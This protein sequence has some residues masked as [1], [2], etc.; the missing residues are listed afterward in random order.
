MD[1]PILCTLNDRELQQRRHE[2]LDRVQAA[3]IRKTEL[4]NGYLY[5]FRP[6]PE[7]VATLKR[8]VA[9]EQECCRFLC[10]RISLKDGRG[11][12]VLEVTGPPV[13]KPVIADFFGGS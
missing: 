4:S 9:L 6:E 10:F 12:L 3:A 1:L 2:I 11:P 8:L 7:M 13:A 5:E